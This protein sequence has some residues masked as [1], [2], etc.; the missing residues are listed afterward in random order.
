[1]RKTKIRKICYAFCAIIGLAII[2]VGIKFCFD[3]PHISSKSPGFPSIAE[4]GADY[5][6]YQY[7]AS[8]YAAI[9]AAY[10]YEILKN[11]IEAL[12]S[13]FGVF[14]IAA[15]SISTL[16]SVMKY[17]LASVEDKESLEKSVIQQSKFPKNMDLASAG[18]N[19]C[20]SEPEQKENE[21]ITHEQ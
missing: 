11:L 19:S 4:F 16:L 7:N 20:E 9:N 21:E 2:V 12:Y 18:E 5:Y 3:P 13:C 8:R 10:C 1:M 15:G 6:T 14:F 17:R